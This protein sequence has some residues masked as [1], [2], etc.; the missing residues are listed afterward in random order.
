M[1]EG[2]KVGKVMCILLLLVCIFDD[3]VYC[4]WDVLLLL[5]NNYVVYC[6]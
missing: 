1:Y 2:W 5:Y 6:V 3:V 4:L